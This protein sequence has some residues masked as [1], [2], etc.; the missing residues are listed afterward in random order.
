MWKQKFYD[1]DASCA[2]NEEWE[3]EVSFDVVD[4]GIGP[5]EYWGIRGADHRFVTTVVD[6]TRQKLRD[7]KP[8]TPLED[9][10]WTPDQESG[11]VENAEPED[12]SEID[13]YDDDKF[14]SKH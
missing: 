14:Y 2:S 3:Y 4:E 10:E 11:W 7:G 12:D 5:Y 8:V 9:V 6:V 13:R 1:Q